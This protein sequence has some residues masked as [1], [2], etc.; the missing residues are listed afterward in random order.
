MSKRAGH[1]SIDVSPNAQSGVNS[2]DSSS[3]DSKENE[4][5]KSQTT[6]I[7]RLPSA[8]ASSQGKGAAAQGQP[9][10]IAQSSTISIKKP[11]SHTNDSDQKIQDIKHS[12]T[13]LTMAAWL[14]KYKQDL[15]PGAGT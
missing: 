13:K 14:R 9:K 6:L 11:H 5:A 7:E 1:V 2:P 15:G 4:R 12:T 8:V 10:G 3:A